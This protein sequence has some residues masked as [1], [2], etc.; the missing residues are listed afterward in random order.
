MS[1]KK[2]LEVGLTHIFPDSVISQRNA[3]ATLDLFDQLD[4]E[5]EPLSP[6]VS[7]QLK[8]K[9]YWRLVPLLMVLNLWLF[10]R[11]LRHVPH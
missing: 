3:D 8:K 7:K 11:I 9:L 4:G 2:S 5:I 6:E 10:V 1:E